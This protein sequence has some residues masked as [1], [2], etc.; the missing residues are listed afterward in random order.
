VPLFHPDARVVDARV[1]EELTAVLFSEE[2]RM[3]AYQVYRLND[4]ATGND[5]TIAILRNR[6]QEMKVGD[7][8]AV[9]IR[10]W[11]EEDADFENKQRFAKDGLVGMVRVIENSY[12]RALQRQRQQGFDPGLT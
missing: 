8:V 11:N 9:Q 1:A 7:F 5:L 2:G 4:V 12:D 3:Q 10:E 6:P